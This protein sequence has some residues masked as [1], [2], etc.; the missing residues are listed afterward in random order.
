MSDM[1]EGLEPRS[2]SEVVLSTMHFK[3]G[4]DSE[5]AVCMCI[6]YISQPVKRFSILIL[7]LS[8]DQKV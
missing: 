5:M 7:A 6:I 2:S 8:S 4:M 1:H 3:A